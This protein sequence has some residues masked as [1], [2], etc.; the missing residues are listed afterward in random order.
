MKITRKQKVADNQQVE[1]QAQP[2]S[3]I[4][5]M[6]K[7]ILADEYVSYYAYFIGAK[8]IRGTNWMDVKQEF[9]QHAEEERKHF[10][11]IANRLYQLGIYCEDTLKDIQR[12]AGYYWDEDTKDPKK[13]V[14]IAKIAEEK[15]VEAYNALL[16]YISDMKANKK[17]FV[18]QRLAKQ[19]LET[20]QDHLQ[21]MER[22]LEEF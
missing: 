4:A 1:D 15:A 11:S 14:E 5:E 3:Q 2:D 18:T 20:E 12:N 10:E 16:V 17:D 21:D 13:A 19:N 8:N 6:L 22:L 9:E 7:K